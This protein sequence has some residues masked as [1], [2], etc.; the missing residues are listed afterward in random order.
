MA[1][2]PIE[3]KLYQEHNEGL[4]TRNLLNLMRGIY[5]LI[6]QYLAHNK[7][8]ALANG[9]LQTL[10]LPPRNTGKKPDAI[11][12]I[13]VKL[14]GGT[15]NSQT[16]ETAPTICIPLS[17]DLYITYVEIINPLRLQQD[18]LTFLW[19]KLNIPPLSKTIRCLYWQGI[20]IKG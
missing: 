8:P 4:S 11:Y 3:I 14:M 15:D 9:S 2:T 12:F 17:N 18:E 6:D 19:L 13:N 7:Y 20:Y 16:D 1:G 5:I 10:P